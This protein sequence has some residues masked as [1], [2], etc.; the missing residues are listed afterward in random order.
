MSIP[1]AWTWGYCGSTGSR[2]DPLPDFFECFNG[3]LPQF[4]GNIPVFFDIGEMVW[5]SILVKQT[6]ISQEEIIYENA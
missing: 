4:S 6:T 1:G 5:Y 2:N 3:S